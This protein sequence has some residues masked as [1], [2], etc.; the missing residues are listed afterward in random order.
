MQVMSDGSMRLWIGSSC[1]EVNKSLRTY[2]EQELA[3]IDATPVGQDPSV[4]SD[5]GGNIAFLG[6]VTKKLVVTPK[7]QF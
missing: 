6:Q 1:F 2:F 4:P 5:A 7:V 3:C